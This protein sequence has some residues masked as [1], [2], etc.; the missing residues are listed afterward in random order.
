MKVG[1]V[2][3]ALG[4]CL[5]SLGAVAANQTQAFTSLTQYISYYLNSMA[6]EHQAAF[7]STC[8]VRSYNGEK[9]QAAIVFFPMKNKGQFL[10]TDKDHNVLN[11]GDVKWDSNGYWD[12]SDL[13]GGIYTIR[14]MSDLFDKLIQLPFTWTSP[15]DV[16]KVLVTKPSHSCT[17]LKL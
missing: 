4:F 17:L 6:K 14:V 3:I 12:I 8:M 16:K 13:E 9:D 15:E 7:V 5:P 10:F 1:A 2:L 11:S